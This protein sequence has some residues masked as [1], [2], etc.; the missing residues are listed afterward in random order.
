[1]AVWGRGLRAKAL[2]ALLLA[3]L[4]V[5]LLGGAL[6]SWVINEV[7]AYFGEAY[8]R[9]FTQLNS[10]RI[11]AP[12][13]RDLALSRQ[14]AR[15][16]VLR[17]W[18]NDADSVSLQGSVWQEVSAFREGFASHSLFLASNVTR[19][20][21][22][23]DSDAP[24]QQL[25]KYRLDSLKSDDAWF[26]N[27]VAQP[28][29]YNVNVNYDRGLSETKVWLNV[30]VR[31]GQQVLGVVGTGLDLSAF[32][33]E[34]VHVQQ[35]GVEAMIL[36]DQGAI[37]V[38]ADVGLIALGSGAGV[39]DQ[40]GGI[41]NLVDTSDHA[42]VRDLLQ[43]ASEAKDTGVVSAWVHRDGADRL[44][45]VSYVPDLRWY[46]VTLLDAGAAGVVQER[47]I[48]LAMVMVLLFIA[49][50]LGVFLYAIER[51]LV[52]PV[53]ALQRGAMALS[54]GDFNVALPPPSS[55]EVGDL[56]RAFASMAKRLHAYTTDLESLV[57]QRTLA[58]EAA[59]A[60]MAAA[61]RKI[62]D[63]I[64]YASSIQQA[65]L[66]AAGLQ[67][68]LGD[69][70]FLL[71]SPR[72]GVGGDF[73]LFSD[74]SPRYLLGVVDCAGHGVPGALMTMLTRAA[75]DQ[76][77]SEAG[78]AS[79][80]TLL[81]RTDEILRGL[82]SQSDWPRGLALQSD[83]GLV[84]V[85]AEARLLRFS[86]AKISLYWSDGLEVGQLPAG[87]RSL[88]DRRSGSW[89]D[90]QITLVSGRVYYLLTDGL[91]DQAGGE[92][93]FGFGYSRWEDMIRAVAGL[94]LAEQR[95]RLAAALADYMQDHEQRDDI[96]VLAFR[97]D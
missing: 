90:Q 19:D 85:D 58:L 14:M 88:A 73:Y 71:W 50:L 15:S 96:T 8:A 45:A 93:G 64:D 16:L 34:F 54:E 36:N 46:V 2:W 78:I 86:G 32:I 29:D 7:R 87:K 95:D 79:P 63:S 5:V 89:Q 13:E 80:A 83:V 49:L 65:L 35:P 28:T 23:V 11:S 41:W 22:Y 44:L 77:M 61:Q 94:P 12:L 40:R 59:N 26:F 62:Q 56:N 1:M 55:D 39:E 4:V 42:R 70:H 82:L 72:D 81:H 92:Q 20:F 69:D 48:W 38:H 74:Q 51:L 52:R 60:S 68:A 3:C 6:G 25:A 17:D 47:W 67:R 18:L 97:F 33:S 37:Q 75:L 27:S 43:Q 91:L 66:P 30:L 10:V 24:R 21:F 53:S 84:W 57:K 31:Q 9:S 76:S